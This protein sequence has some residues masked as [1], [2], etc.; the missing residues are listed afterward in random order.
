MTWIPGLSRYYAFKLLAETYFYDPTKQLSAGVPPCNIKS[1]NLFAN[2]ET[3]LEMLL[4]ALVYLS[5]STILCRGTLIFVII[6]LWTLAMNHGR[7][8]VL[9]SD[10]LTQRE[11]TIPSETVLNAIISSGT[12]WYCDCLFIDF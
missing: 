4:S 1:P 10:W 5:V 3:N 7:H 6:L 12:L 8:V 11:V 2:V 9:F